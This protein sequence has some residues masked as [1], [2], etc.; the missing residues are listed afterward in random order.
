[1]GAMAYYKFTIGLDK[2]YHWYFRWAGRIVW[3]S[4]TLMIYVF[5]RR[6]NFD[7]MGNFM[8]WGETIALEAFG[9]AWL[10]KGRFKE[11]WILQQFKSKRK[12]KRRK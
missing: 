5:L 11:M 1:M 3:I 9:I 7:Y 2:G 6:P 12:S 4:L 8:F 10:I